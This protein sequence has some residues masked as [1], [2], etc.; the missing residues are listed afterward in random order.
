M[1]LLKGKSKKALSTNIGTL[2]KDF[3]QTG[4]I[5]NATPAT[6]NKARSQAVA[7]AFGK[8]GKGK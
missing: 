2:V 6:M 8:A 4:K 3:K 7:I 1:P 5:G